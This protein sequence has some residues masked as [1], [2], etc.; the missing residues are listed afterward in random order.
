MLRRDSV[1]AAAILGAAIRVRRFSEPAT[2]PARWSLA[3]M[4]ELSAGSISALLRSLAPRGWKQQSA[5]LA[6]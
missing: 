3:T 6:E 2:Y 1:P 5:V 4:S